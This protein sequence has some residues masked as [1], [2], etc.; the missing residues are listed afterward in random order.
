MSS[1]FD[2]NSSAPRHWFG[3][4]FRERILAGWWWLGPSSVAIAII[5]GSR[6][7]FVRTIAAMVALVALR[8]FDDL[9]DVDHDRQRHPKRALC[10]LDSL[11]PV[12][13][14]CVCALL[15]SALA[16]SVVGSNIA[17]Y[18][19][20]L[21]LVLLAARLRQNAAS[22]KRIVIAHV[23]LFKFPALAIA[24]ASNDVLPNRLWIYSGCLYG[25][26]GAYE[27]LHDAEARRSKWTNAL[28]GLD[29]V[30]LTVG[31]MSCFWSCFD[32]RGE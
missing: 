28:F 22:T 17:F 32:G 23:I 13:I 8:L 9:A 6:D 26:V 11:V 5:G 2:G 21:L 15:F 4:W 20:V 24:L 30:C 19:G 12:H 14:A 27:V 29:M 16:I 1:G 18:L 3:A 31:L 10:Q 25:F 7:W